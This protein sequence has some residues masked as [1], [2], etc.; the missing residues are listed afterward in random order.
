[1]EHLK[2]CGIKWVLTNHGIAEWAVCS[3]KK[4]NA[5]LG[6]PPVVSNMGNAWT[7]LTV[8]LS[9]SSFSI[10]SINCSF[11]SGSKLKKRD[12]DKLSAKELQ[13]FTLHKILMDLQIK[14]YPLCVIR[15]QTCLSVHTGSGYFYLNSKMAYLLLFSV[16]HY[17]D[18]QMKSIFQTPKNH[19]HQCSFAVT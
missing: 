15:I 18:S 16:K 12:R 6:H 9:F 10:T 4:R 17:M 3:A 7:V 2:M 13:L 11:W 14:L 19:H 1:M 8:L 5:W